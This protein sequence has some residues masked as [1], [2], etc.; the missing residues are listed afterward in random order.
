MPSILPNVK[1]G[2]GM[3]PGMGGGGGG[4]P[5]MGGGMMG[6]EK[7]KK[8]KKDMTPD[9]LEARARKKAKK[10][11]KMEAKMR[12]QQQQIDQAGYTDEA[13]TGETAD[14][15]G[16]WDWADPS[17]ANKDEKD[18]DPE[19]S[20]DDFE[21]E[22][23]GNDIMVAHPPVQQQSSKGNARSGKKKGGGLALPSI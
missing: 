4:L 6:G 8:S 2:G 20:D 1:G 23:G 14:A 13:G 9:E 12:Q 10:K 5:S 18:E 7:V 22:G 17:G 11:A 21:I 19:Y 16:G 3:L 15:V